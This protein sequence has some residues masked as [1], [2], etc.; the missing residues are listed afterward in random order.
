MKERTS[1]QSA[2]SKE[3]AK[4]ALIAYRETFFARGDLLNQ[5][6]VQTTIANYL[7]FGDEP[8]ELAEWP[9]LKL[10]IDAAT[11]RR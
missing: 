6:E 5:L 9:L 4:A 2:I 10:A 3:D 8:E 11:E 1:Q 7:L